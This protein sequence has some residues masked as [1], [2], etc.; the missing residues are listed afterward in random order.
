M[1]LEVVARL[2]TIVEAQVVCGAL[3]AAGFRAEVFDVGPGTVYWETM[4]AGFRVVVPEDDLKDAV[5][6]LAEV[7]RGARE[8]PEPPID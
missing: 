1:G 7:R 4:T 5:A 2:S 3:R 6:Y 8:D